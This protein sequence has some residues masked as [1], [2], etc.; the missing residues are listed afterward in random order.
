MNVF[1]R[2]SLR[3]ALPLTL[4]V[5]LTG[6]LALTV[7]HNLYQGRQ[8]IE[9]QAIGQV[10]QKLDQLHG[11]I[12]DSLLTDD[13]PAVQHMVSM[14]SADAD[15]R[16]LLV[17]DGDGV[18]RAANRFEWVGSPF[19]QVPGALPEAL[20]YARTSDV[21]RIRLAPGGR[22][23]VAQT[24]L[25]FAP[26]PGELRSSQVGVLLMLY[27]L[28][29]A[30]QMAGRDSLLS[31][32]TDWLAIALMA[33][34]IYLLFHFSFN[35]RIQRLLTGIGRLRDGDLSTRLALPGRD[36]LAQVAHAVDD[37]AGQ[38]ATHQRELAAQQMAMA[39]SS[40]RYRALFESSLDG[41]VLIDEMG[42][43]VDANPTFRRLAGLSQDVL[44]GRAFHRLLDD[45]SRADWN[46]PMR[47]QL[48]S[49]GYTDEFELKLLTVAGEPAA[50]A[51]KCMRL[52]DS[53]GV[54]RGGWCLLRD[55]SERKQAAIEQRLA[56]A[57]YDSSSEAILVT[58]PDFRVCMVNPA[59]VQHTGQDTVTLA[60]SVLPAFE[61]GRDPRNSAMLNA[62]QRD[63]RWQGEHWM[64]RGNGETFPVWL[65]CAPALGDDGQVSH[66]IALFSDISE[67]IATEQRMRYLAEHDELTG[68]AN[69]F[70]F[71]QGLEARLDSAA[72]D[73]QLA[74]MFVDLDRF[75]PINDMMGHKVGDDLLRRVAER[76]TEVMGELAVVA[77]QSADEFILFAP[78]VSAGEAEQL[79]QMMVGMLAQPYRVG[80]YELSIAASVGVSCY[81]EHGLSASRL[82]KHAELAMSQAKRTGGSRALCYD[83]N[84]QEGEEERHALEQ[85][86]RR[87]IER[88]DLLLEYQPQLNL[89]TR[90]VSAVEAL[91][92]WRHPTL[93][94]ISP[95]KFIPL[96]EETGLIQPIGQ[97][98]LKE[99]CRQMADW[100]T[101]DL[102]LTVAVNLSALQLRHAGLFNDVYQA[103]AQSGV[104]ASFLELELTESALMEN[105]DAMLD[106][107]REFDELG[108]QLSI[109]DF[110]T[111]YSSLAYLRHLPIGELKIDRS[112]V[113]DLET[114]PHAAP[115]VEAILAMAHSLGLSV[116]AEGVE[117]DAQFAFLAAKGCGYVQGWWLAKSMPAAELER[118]MAEYDIGAVAERISQARQPRAVLLG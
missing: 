118:W 44:V 60:G 40:A 70:A 28:E 75:K 114:D 36:E 20:S 21:S 115:I 98:V 93:G 97:W 77:R 116:V 56:A 25:L 23:V 64:S 101:R 95:A 50:V 15:V 66:Y 33:S 76:I 53:R 91:L 42:D 17:V 10:T 110:G 68:L 22:W 39:E 87:A 38:L 3:L 1:H 109:D 37:M 5:M 26:E 72:P 12:A 47:E 7:G 48:E 117:T 79:G 84:M 32:L 62:L 63:G 11:L 46:G 4:L 8:R 54:R 81:P 9:Q 59:F 94:W 113:K 103:L 31:A 65:S 14:A 29:R 74:V 34:V 106:T 57:V 86:L 16:M 99:A 69:R 61:R 24:R 111:G 96:A 19:S 41:I 92:R 18:V 88:G 85:D 73:S 82:L 89:D 67:R 58:D 52:A 49:R 35:R 27:D 108:V 2:F 105:I 55:L 13:L 83:P 100:H 78:D 90:E 102:P 80:P 107:L 6:T 43:V 71:M 30:K 112:F 51:T 45:D 104:E